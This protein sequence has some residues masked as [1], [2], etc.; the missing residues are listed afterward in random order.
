MTTSCNGIVEQGGERVTYVN[1]S[2]EIPQLLSSVYVTTKLCVLEDENC[3]FPARA[4]GEYRSAF[5]F[6]LTHTMCFLTWIK[7]LSRFGGRAG[8]Y[9]SPAS[10]FIRPSSLYRG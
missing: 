2:L 6:A 4:R 8:L 9:P 7:H 5:Y 10:T 3:F 1:E